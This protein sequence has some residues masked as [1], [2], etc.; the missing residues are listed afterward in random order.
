[1]RIHLFLI[2][3][4][5]A[6]LL[7]AG[8]RGGLRGA[9][10]QAVTEVIL[11]ASIL[12]HELAHCG[13]ARKAGAAAEEILLWPLGGLA[14]VGRTG[15]ARDEI[16]V[17]AAGPLSNFLLGGLVLGALILTGAPW[18]WEY[19]NPFAPW[20]DLPLL[21]RAQLFLLHAV[22]INLILGL[23]NLCVPAYPLDGG[24]ILYSW[25][26]LRMDRAGAAMVTARIALVIG[27][28]MA[29][30]GWAQGDF[31]LLLIGLWVLVEAFQ[32]LR[33]VRMGEMEA[34]PAFGAVGPEY[35]PMPEEPR[36]GFLARWRAR[37]ARRRAEREARRA[38]ELD[39]AVDAILEKVGR[40][41]IASLTPRER[42]ILEEASRRRRGEG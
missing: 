20:W 28:V 11:F 15:S 38:E 17:A 39:R 30:W 36:P 41:G 23:F 37:R 18:S 5:A 1:M 40:E 32:V 42:R 16:R 6:L 24:R 4:L 14:Y 13:A 3:L 12:I 21:S 10:W 35:A 31:T 27:A 25:L 8:A 34:H 26:T 7:Q 22:R 19:L 2:L 9:G 29:V 33:L